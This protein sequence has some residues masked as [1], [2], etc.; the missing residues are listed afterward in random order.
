MSAPLA[1]PFVDFKAHVAAHRRE[2]DAA[3]A[4]VLDS[5][6]FILGPEGEAFE[7]ELAAALGAR[8]AVAVNDP[9]AQPCPEGL[10]PGFGVQMQGSHRLPDDVFIERVA[11]LAVERCHQI[12]DLV[13]I[14]ASRTA[15]HDGGIG[16]HDPARYDGS[17]PETTSRIPPDA[18]VM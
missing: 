9:E 13:E 3:V 11:V 4:R 2:L 16:L 14:R 6:W 10:G 17:Q 1:V 12:H 18:E 15:D 8:D 7:R 5:G